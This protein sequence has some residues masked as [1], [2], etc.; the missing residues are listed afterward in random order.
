MRVCLISTSDLAHGAAVASYMLHRALRAAG[1]ASTLL[2]V[3]K[4]SD[5]PDVLVLNPEPRGRLRYLARKLEVRVEQTLNLVG[6]QNQYSI[7]ARGLLA[8]PEIAAADVVHVHNLHW[9]RH[10][11]TTRI[12]PRLCRAKPVAWTFHDMWPVTGHCIY[13]LGCERWRTGCGRCPSLD[14]HMSL[15]LD[16]SAWLMRIKRRTYAR[17]PFTAVTPSRWLA[18]IARASPVLAGHA[19]RCIAN[20]IDPELEPVEPAQARAALG[21]APDRPTLLFAS[22]QLS[23]PFKGAGAFERCLPALLARHPRAQ[24]LAFGDGHLSP[25]VRARLPVLPLGRIASPR[26]KSLAYSAADVLVHPSLADNL[27]NMV[28][29]AMACGTPSA[30]FATGGLSEMLTAGVTGELAPPDDADGLAHAIATV[31]DGAAPERRAACLAAFRARYAPERIVA[32]HV[33]LYEE[34]LRARTAGAA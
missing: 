23:N 32:E 7:A 14:T 21:L 11:L 4:L 22:N 2:V 26:L 9:P 1:H 29:E 19:V 18:D 20:V 34:L 16:T 27:P 13:S 15:A 25:G 3:Q 31:L 8:R 30:A 6:P 24:L 17:A 12:L 28:L 10:N 33:A 5:D